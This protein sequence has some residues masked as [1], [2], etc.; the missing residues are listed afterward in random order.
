[1]SPRAKLRARRIVRWASVVGVALASGLVPGRASADGVDLSVA[2][3]GQRALAQ[4]R[5][6]QGKALYDKGAFAAAFEEFQRANDIIASPN[7]RLYA[8]RCLREQGRLLEAY[9]EF[10]RTE[11]DV[12]EHA[13]SDERYARASLA[14]QRERI[15]I[16]TKLA[17][18]TVRVDHPK[19]TTILHI[20]GREIPRHAWESAIPVMPG[21]TEIVVSD[22]PSP[23]VR[24]D[25]SAAAGEHKV[26]VIDAAPQP[27]GPPRA[28]TVA[29]VHSAGSPVVRALGVVSLGV[30]VQG[31][32]AFAVSGLLSRAAYSDL[33]AS[34]PDRQCPA[35][36]QSEV[37]RGRDE[38]IVANVGVVVGSVGVALGAGLLL[39][40]AMKGRPE[41]AT[42]VVVSAA[43]AGVRF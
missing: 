41:A 2:T 35:S 4:A 37:A 7:S 12:R 31:W 28:P 9:A 34:C 16:G 22:P 15:E 17:F 26:V 29:E 13:S 21:A 14:A 32:V 1:M 33:T 43:G 18:V 42:A 40:G 23:D 3:S 30:G 39:Y 36:R 8:A 19:G 10:E 5:F 27:V 24:Q 38:Q 6:A 25:V 20:A 11:R